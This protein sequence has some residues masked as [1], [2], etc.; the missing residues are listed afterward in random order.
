VLHHQRSPDDL[1]TAWCFFRQWYL[2]DSNIKFYKRYQP[3]PQFH[4][5]IVRDIGSYSYNAVAA[6]RGFSKS[7]VLTLELP[8]MLMLTRPYFNIL[9][10]L[11]KDTMVTKRMNIQIKPQLDKNKRILADFGQCVPGKGQGVASAH[12]LQLLNGASLEAQ[13]VK[14]SQLGARPDLILVDDAEIDPVLNQV[15][16][17][18]RDNFDRYLT[19]HIMPMMDIDDEAEEGAS[20]YWIGTLLTK[21]CYLYHVVTTTS[22]ERFQYWNRRLLDAEDDGHGNLLWGAKFSE[23]RL[24]REKQSLGAAAYN[25]QRRNRPGT[26]T[27]S[28]LTIHSQ[29]GRYEV[30]NEDDALLTN[31]LASRSTLVSWLQEGHDSS[32]NKVFKRIERPFGQTVAR[33]RRVLMM[34]YARCLTPQ[35]DYVA[36]VVVGVESSEVYKGAWWVLDCLVGRF[37]GN[38]WV[39]KFWDMS[40]KW[41]CVYAG[42]EDVGAQGVCLDTASEEM[43]VRELKDGWIARPV[44]IKVPRG[45]SKEDRIAGALEWRFKRDKVKLP[46]GRRKE[47]SW[48]ELE[49]EIEGFTGMPGAT[50]HDDAIDALAMG[51][52]LLRGSRRGAEIPEDDVVGW[53]ERLVRNEEETGIQPGLGMTVNDLTAEDMMMLMQRWEDEQWASSNHHGLRISRV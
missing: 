14:G 24:E 9:L 7:T 17:E 29:G 28:V 41:R 37:P 34:D 43:E 40:F 53:K 33:M 39:S 44:P 38:T 23:A 13:A 15:T 2:R 32:G 42:I 20:L 21:Q 1:V 3:S 12:M 50:Q 8:M 52:S 30:E 27:G 26:G 4:Y 10:V 51:Q 49:D 46:I 6:P 18:L 36:L 35:S 22:D 5:E 19:N 47:F 11:S 48:R 16:P 31:P 25:A 45:I